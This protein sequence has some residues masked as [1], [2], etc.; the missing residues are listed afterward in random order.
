MNAR[1]VMVVIL[2]ASALIGCVSGAPTLT[3]EQEA[4]VSAVQVFKAGDPGPTQYQS[5]GTMSA[6]DCSGAPG[7]GRVWGEA[8]KAIAT[9]KE[10]AVAAGADALIG[11]SCSA[12]PFVNNCW[13]AQKCTGEAVKTASIGHN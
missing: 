4:Q 1:K 3:T 2:G 12:A 9:L 11:V 6:A 5:L 10:K 13:S 7:G 8:E